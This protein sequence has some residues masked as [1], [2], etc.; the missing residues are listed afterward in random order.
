MKK[1]KHGLVITFK[2]LYDPR[3]F[4]RSKYFGAFTDVS[5]I[6]DFD[7]APNAKVLNQGLGGESSCTAHANASISSIQEGVDLSP[8]YAMQATRRVTGGNPH[9][10]G[11][12]VDDAMKAHVKFG[13]LESKDSPLS[14]EKD[15]QYKVEDPTNWD[16]TLDNK[17]IEHQKDSY[18][19]CDGYKD[20]FDSTRVAMW[21]SFQTFLRTNNPS[22]KK[23]PSIGFYWQ[24]EWT[25]QASISMPLYPTKDFP[26]NVF[27]RGQKTINGQPY[28]IIHNSYG[29][30]AGDGGVHYFPRDVFNK[31]VAF[32]RTFEDI[33]PERVKRMQWGLLA[34]MA[35]YLAM[36]SAWLT[37]QNQ[38]KEEPEPIPP[39]LP[40][41]KKS[42]LISWGK[43]IERFES[44]PK[45]WN[46]PGA[47]KKLSGGFIKF[48]TYEAGWNYLL[49]YLKRA[50]TGQHKAYPKGG[51][52][53][54]LDFQKIYSPAHDNNDPDKYARYVANQLGVDPDIEI[55]F[56][57]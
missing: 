19:E 53:T 37:K 48:K 40:E 22:H 44:A 18:M 34:L 33:D 32:S 45:Q 38:P 29:K 31:F 24:P 30:D 21:E 13:C 12:N 3:T 50:A 52:T 25:S 2:T 56:L 35:N 7:L 39:P 8:E 57:L 11:A 23:A 55:K 1:S 6:T 10:W 51:D 41:P 43:A 9:V 20:K 47:I 26:H 15:G 5:K 14:F 4:S 16:K 54:L 46:N 28:I 27:A 49:D 36:L 42:L 17:A